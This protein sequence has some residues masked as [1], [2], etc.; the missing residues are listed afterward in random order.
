M[1]VTLCAIVAQKLQLARSLRQRTSRFPSAAHGK[2]PLTFIEVSIMAV[3]SITSLL[4][5]RQTREHAFIYGTVYEN[6][7]TRI[8]SAVVLFGY[9][10]LLNTR[11]Y[12][13]CHNYAIPHIRIVFSKTKSW[14]KTCTVRH[15][16]AITIQI[17][18]KIGHI[19][20]QHRAANASTPKPSRRW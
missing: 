2:R 9:N 18:N 6:P 10:N 5:T 19:W 13:A 1:V 4:T 7:F 3:P 8:F 15:L 17:G 12:K 11:L 20:I 14:T 16:H